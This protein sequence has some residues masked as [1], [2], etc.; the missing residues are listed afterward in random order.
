MIDNRLSR[1][2][3]ILSLFAIIG[4]VYIHSNTTEPRMQLPGSV[5]EDALHLNSFTQFF[6]ANGLARFCIPLFFCISGFLFFQCSA[7]ENTPRFLGKIVKRLRTIVLPFLLWSLAGFFLT[8]LLLYVPFYKASVPFPAESFWEFATNM[9]WGAVSYHL[10]FLAQLFLLMLF[11]YPIFRL[12]KTPLAYAALAAVFYF[13]MQGI[14]WLYFVS[15]DALLFFMLG[16]LFAVRGINLHYRIGRVPAMALLSA[17]VL[18]TAVKTLLAYRW[19]L[20]HVH[21]LTVLLGLAVVWFCY[22]HF[23]QPWPRWSDRL[24]KIADHS[25]FIYVAHVPLLDLTLDSL[26]KYAGH[27]PWSGLATFAVVPPLFIAG[28]VLISA[29]IRRVAPGFYGMLTGGRGLDAPPVLLKE[30]AAI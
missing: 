1:K 17:W 9:H 22:D 24:G 28:L 8:R 30:K 11:G 18:L 12:L 20:P 25:F 2:L 4:V 29:S 16:G 6:V 10:W 21:Q 23:V 5:L 19:S 15:T 13:W 7:G 14:G 27:T 26:L 3:K